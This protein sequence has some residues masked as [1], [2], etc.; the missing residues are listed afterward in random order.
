M[1]DYKGTVCKICQVRFTKTL[2]TYKTLL[3][4]LL[5]A[6]FALQVSEIGKDSIGLRISAIQ[7]R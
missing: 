3:Y 6:L 7:F 2:C 1:P 5:S 4:T